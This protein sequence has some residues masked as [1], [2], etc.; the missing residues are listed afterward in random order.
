LGY[1][2]IYQ[3]VE[4]NVIQPTVQSRSVELSALMVFIAAIAGIMLLGLVGGILAIPFAGCVRVLV[5]DY[6]DHRHKKRQ[7]H[8]LAGETEA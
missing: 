8:K 4:N 7:H 1:F 3:Q 5:L 6:I 2:L